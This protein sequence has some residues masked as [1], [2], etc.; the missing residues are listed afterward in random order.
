MILPYVPLITLF[1]RYCVLP[2]TLRFSR[3]HHQ[4]CIAVRQPCMSHERSFC[5]EVCVTTSANIG[6]YCNFSL[7]QIALSNPIWLA[8]QRGL[9][10]TLHALWKRTVLKI[11]CIDVLDWSLANIP[12]VS[13]SF[14]TRT[15]WY[16]GLRTIGSLQ[17]LYEKFMKFRWIGNAD[18]PARIEDVLDYS[19]YDGLNP[20]RDSR[21]HIFFDNHATLSLSVLLILSERYS[22]SFLVDCISSNG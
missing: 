20:S 6:W 8:L 9:K 2:Y 13:S 21:S 14:S 22:L 18:I 16:V 12:Q 5:S 11:R 19:L 10:M 7:F 4:H 17:A 15:G 3:L 1:E